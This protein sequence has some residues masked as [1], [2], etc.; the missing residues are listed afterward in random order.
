MHAGRN[1]VFAVDYEAL[2]GRTRGGLAQLI[3][4][5]YGQAG[6]RLP[7]PAGDMADLFIGLVHGLVLKRAPAPGAAVRLVFDGLMTAAEPG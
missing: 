3:A 2:Q 1:P 7:I 5:L 6:K 4:A